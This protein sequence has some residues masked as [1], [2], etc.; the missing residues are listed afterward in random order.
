MWKH[1]SMHDISDVFALNR[2]Q[3]SMV[4][5]GYFSFLY[6]MAKLW[7][8][9]TAPAALWCETIMQSNDFENEKGVNVTRTTVVARLSLVASE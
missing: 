5:M 4:F 3:R 9:L 6:L 7:P 8:V 2:A 1:G